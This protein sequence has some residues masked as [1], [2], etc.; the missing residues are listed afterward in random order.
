VTMA[1]NR[2]TK[3]DLLI[4]Y[5]KLKYAI[6]EVE[7]IHPQLLIERALAE[8]VLETIEGKKE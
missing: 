2:E 6:K 5:D 1:R 3:E 7:E 4:A 8:V